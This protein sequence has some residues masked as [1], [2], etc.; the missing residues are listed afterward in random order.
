[1]MPPEPIRMERVAAPTLER[2]TSGAEQ[3]SVAM[4]WC[5]DIQKRR[6][7]SASAHC[8]RSTDRSRA[9]PAVAPAATGA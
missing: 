9:S 2:T 7:P 1:M 3:A 6:K 5:S 4:A 8:A